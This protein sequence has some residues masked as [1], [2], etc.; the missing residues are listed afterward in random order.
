MRVASSCHEYWQS[1][2]GSQRDNQAQDISP[3]GL[4]G[5][6]GASLSALIGYMS[7]AKPCNL[8]DGGDF[9]PERMLAR[10]AGAASRPLA[11]KTKKP[12]NAGFF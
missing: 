6:P 1:R 5:M 2:D 10:R 12:G 4:A 11:G 8:R 3:V 7:V 9:L